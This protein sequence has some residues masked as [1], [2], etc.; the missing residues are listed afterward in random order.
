MSEECPCRTCND[1]KVGC[2]TTCS[3][4]GTWKEA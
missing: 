2:H 4:Y 1:R 3:H